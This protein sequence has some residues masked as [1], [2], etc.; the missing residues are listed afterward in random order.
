MMRDQ[1]VVIGGGLAGSEA[2]WQAAERGA[3]VILYEMRPM[4]GT[5]AHKTG[6]LAEIVCSNSLGSADP[7]SAPGL[8]KEEMRLLNS[9]VMRA[10]E[11]ARVPAGAALAV[12]RDLFAQ[13]V[14]NTLETHPN[15]R[16]VREEV[17]EIPTDALCI[18]ATGPLTS[19]RMSQALTA[20][21]QKKNLAFFDAIS[22]I[23]DAESIDMQKV[24]RASRYGKG[25]ADYL[26]CPMDDKTYTAFYDALMAAEKVQA[27]DFEQVPYFEGC[28]P[29][30]AMAER[31]KQTLTFGPMK[32]VGLIDPHTGKQSHAVLQLRAENRYGSCY[33]MVG[34]QTKLKY[35][36][37]KRVFRMIPGLERAEFLR[38]GSVHR[39]TFVNA[40]ALLRNTLQ[41][42]S[43]GTTLLA[44]CLIGVE[45][46]VESAA[47]GGLA[48]INAARALANLP[49]VTPPLTTAHGALINYLT[50]SDARYFQPMNTNFGLFPPLPAKIRDKV[51]RRRMIHQRALDEFQAWKTQ[52]VVS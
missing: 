35:P 40:P 49:M 31:G 15:I 21:T 43:R 19:E 16:I 9:L 6:Q 25:G 8:L 45:G 52:F 18:V 51:Q 10:A 36:E 33:N 50:T 5:A 46:Y 14:T 26:N 2:A 13:E 23:I 34:F 37:Q 1:V 38:F 44:G 27:K 22:P 3:S 7:V 41:L 47:T 30:E 24:F 4:Q 48:G 12:D 17:Q 11:L 29:I 20:L 39:N 42:K 28:I 32:P